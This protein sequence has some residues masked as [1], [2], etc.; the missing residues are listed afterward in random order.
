[1]AVHAFGP[2]WLTQ[3]L[4]HDLRLAQRSDV[5]FIS[6]AVASRNPPN[7]S[8]YNMAKAAMES[9]AMSLAYEERDN[10][11]HVNVIAPGLV[12]TDMG[13]RLAAARAGASRSAAELDVRYPFGHVCRPQEIASVVAFLCSPAA[14]YMTGQKIC[15]D[16]EL[17][18]DTGTGL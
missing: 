11:L 5:V 9:F 6:S 7:S 1:M 3:L 18:V 14:S 4:L 15:V 17:M 10:G 16:G 2:F 12:V 13:D 8:P